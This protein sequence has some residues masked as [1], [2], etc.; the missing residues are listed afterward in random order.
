MDAMK[1]KLGRKLLAGFGAVLT[2]MTIIALISMTQVGIL[3]S[4]VSTLADKRITQL[5]ILYDVIKQYDV[6]TRSALNISLTFDE[7]MQVKFEGQ[8]KKSRV[9][10]VDTLNRLGKTLTTDKGKKALGNVNDAVAGV[11]PQYDRAVQLARANQNADAADIFM[12]QVSPAESK[13][14][15]ALDELASAVQA[16]SQEDAQTARR[17]STVGGTL[18]VLLGIVAVVAGFAIALLLIKKLTGPINRAAEGLA[19][20]SDHVSSAAEQMTSSSQQLASATSEQSA[21]LE[22]TSA[23]LEEMTSMTRQNAGNAGHAKTLM[24]ENTK[25][26]ERANRQ[27]HLM[28]EAIQEVTKS[29]EETS[30]IIRTIDE[31]AF[32]TNLLALNAA[33]EAARAG[34]AGAGFAVV[35]DEVRNLAMRS[36]Q[37]AKDTTALIENTI[38]TVRKSNDLTHETRKSF[39]EN[40][41]IAGKIS[42]LVD[43]IASASQEQARG[44]DQ[45]RSAVTDMD[46]VIQESAATAEESAGT[47][48]LLSAQALQMRAHV[49]ELASV[50]GR[51]TLETAF[52]SQPG[53]WPGAMV[54]R[55]RIEY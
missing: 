26:V 27:V 15:G 16:A 48:E 35:A 2:L 19:E 23:S 32:Q 8:Y 50:V 39:Q 24:D 4:K 38:E 10:V 31:I 6:M 42:H 22:E 51:S 29:S 20:A 49:T 7:S 3:G 9:A 5:Q 1:F 37:A 28:A 54:S 44:I 13:L 17:I 47:A 30:K 52:R 43:E 46:K 25:I 12:K 34:E 14:M 36:A 45:I 33:V 21:S 11:W 40:V 41:L 18:I 55:E 53:G